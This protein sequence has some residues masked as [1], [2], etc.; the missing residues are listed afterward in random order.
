MKFFKNQKPNWKYILIVIILAIIV[1][2]GILYCYLKFPRV[3]FPPIKFPP[4]L[5]KQITE[6]L[7]DQLKKGRNEIG[8]LTVELIEVSEQDMWEEVEEDWIKLSV[9][10]FTYNNNKYEIEVYGEKGMGTGGAY[11]NYINAIEKKNG[12]V[13]KIEIDG[14]SS[15]DI[16][17]PKVIAYK[18]HLYIIVESG[19]RMTG[20]RGWYEN[21]IFSIDRNN[22]LED[23]KTFYSGEA[24]TYRSP[25]IA[26]ITS[27]IE[28]S[29]ALY[30]KIKNSYCYFYSGIGLKIDWTCS[31]DPPKI[32][33]APAACI[34]EYYLLNGKLIKSNSEFKNEYLKAALTYNEIL[35]EKKWDKLPPVE[36][37]GA[38]VGENWISV[39]LKRTLNYIFA[40]E[41]KAWQTFDEDFADF[42]SKYPLEEVKEMDLNKI[43]EEVQRQI[44][45]KE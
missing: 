41:E 45:A 15:P 10:S 18:D 30:I 29:Q 42:S 6:I 3:K 21:T 44:T 35:Q 26:E 13:K 36:I 43:K 4:K 39:L 25:Y 33:L 14:F 7:L 9:Y 20:L 23:K 1:G 19:S 32:P 28:K 8:N 38:T 24:L 11:S 34:D 31:W 2:G 5:E 12:E 22:N 17:P 37:C 27:L 16:I 40:G